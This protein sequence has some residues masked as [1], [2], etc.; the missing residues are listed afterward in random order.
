M[1]VADAVAAL[2]VALLGITT[3]ALARQLP[4]DAEYG[5]G[6]GFLPLWLGATLLVLSVFL[7]RGALRAGAHPE[8]DGDDGRE[9]FLQFAPGALTPWLI[10][11]ASTV[12]VSLLFDRLGFGL[13]VGLYMLV[14][15]RWVVRQSWLATIGLAIATP[16]VLYLGFVRILMVPLPLAP[17]GF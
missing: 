12:A 6:P 15:M 16:L 1:R 14:T 11:F 10:F 13:S 2:C 9:G 8:A 4:Y 7:L 17:P 5:P 3:I